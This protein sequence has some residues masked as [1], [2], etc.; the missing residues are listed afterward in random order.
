MDKRVLSEVSSAEAALRAAA[1]EALSSLM[2]SVPTPSSSV[3]GSSPL[4]VLSVGKASS[5][6]ATTSTTKAPSVQSAIPVHV[7]GS[8]HGFS[9]EML[10]LPLRDFKTAIANLPEDERITARHCRRNLQN[11]NASG[12]LRK[13]I[14]NKLQNAVNAEETFKVT[15]EKM[16]Q[17]VSECAMRH[18]QQHPKLM[19]T[20]LQDVGTNLK[21]TLPPLV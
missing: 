16:L 11:R 20:F 3:E 19:E 15:E 9:E 1:S 6:T 13:R 18:F 14:R 7:R 2:N 4:S 17:I 10:S 21:S 12:S 8:T 5:S